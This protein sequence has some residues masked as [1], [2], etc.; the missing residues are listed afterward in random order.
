MSSEIPP[1]PYFSGINFNPAFFRSIY[2]YL[3]EQIANTLYLKLRGGSLSG[4][5][6]IK[7]SPANVELDMTGKI[8]ISGVGGA[9]ENGLYGGVGTK[10]ILKEGIAS[11]SPPVALG[12]VSDNLW[13]GNGNTGNIS[14]YTGLTERMT[15]KNNGNVGIGTTDSYYK[16]QIR[17]A[18]P[19]LLRVETNLNGV[20][21][22]SGIEFGTPTILG[23]GSSKITSQ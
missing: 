6:G 8:N 22:V 16:L 17:G 21:Q 15:I 9:P 20:G 10:L 11:L 5:L 13:I 1:V 14:I 18:S 19:S 7:K 2:D 4:N 3:T 12:V 23:N